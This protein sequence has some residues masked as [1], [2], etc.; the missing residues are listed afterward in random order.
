MAKKPSFMKKMQEENAKKRED[1]K[2][3]LNGERYGHMSDPS[4]HWSCGGY[5]RGGMNLFY[6]PS[7][8]G[9]STFSL[10]FAG[11][12]HKKKGG[13][14]LVLDTEN[15]YND[16]HEVSESG[17][18]S[19]GAINMRKRLD[20]AGID[21]DSFLLWK[22]N[23]PAEIFKPLQSMREDLIKDPA[24]VAAIIVDSW[25]GIQNSQTQKKLDGGKADEVG[26]AYGGNAK[27]INPILKSLV[28]LNVSFGVTVFSVQ[29]V[30]M[31]IEEYGPKWTIPGG[32]TFVHLHNMIMLIEG[33]ETKKNSLLVGD[34]RG[35]STSDMAMKIGKMVRFKCD[36]SRACVEGRQGEMFVNFQD[37]KFAKPEESLFNLASR[38]GVIVHPINE[39]TG[40][41]NNLWWQYPAEAETPIKFKGGVN[42]IKSLTEDKNL[43]NEIWQDCLSSG[44]LIAT[45]ES[46]GS[47]GYRNDDGKVVEVGNKEA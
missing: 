6:G 11:Q 2:K 4:L 12:E 5:M 14:V 21:I 25:E 33:S 23:R 13:I 10:I 45:D 35:G 38:L 39:K 20:A 19:E 42:V 22:S 27:S 16:P 9:K 7:K 3:S 41:S 46:L 18:L 34:E 37:L 28:D 30:R 40:A 17:E 44:K 31:N 24:C 1:I 15:A 29:H 26:N 8:S 36:K 32:Q 43:Y 47:T